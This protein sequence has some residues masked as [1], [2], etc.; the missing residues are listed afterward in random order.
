VLLSSIFFATY[1][2]QS[3]ASAV[4]R[5]FPNADCEQIKSNYGKHLQEAAIDDFDFVQEF[6]FQKVSSGAWMC[7]CQ[8]EVAQGKSN[9]LYETNEGLE[10]I[11]DLY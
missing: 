11:C 3:K 8:D 7:F 2:F 6:E 4:A 10:S 1:F 9:A 5:V